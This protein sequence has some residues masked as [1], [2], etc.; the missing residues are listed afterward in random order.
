MSANLPSR[1][2]G[3]AAMSIVLV[4]G[5]IGALFVAPHALAEV[6]L[7]SLSLT[8]EFRTL[9]PVAESGGGRI[10]FAEGGGLA[11]L[12]EFAF[13][14][15]SAGG[16]VGFASEGFNR[17]KGQAMALQARSRLRSG[18]TNSA[19]LF[20]RKPRVPPR[21]DTLELLISHQSL[22]PL[23]ANFTPTPAAEFV[24]Q[25]IADAAAEGQR[26]F[27]IVDVG[28]SGK[29]R[30]IKLLSAEGQVTDTALIEAVRE[31]VKTS[32]QD[33]RRHDHTVYMAYQVQGQTVARVGVPIVTLPEC[34]IV[35]PGCE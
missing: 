33:E 27:A 4:A 13:F 35:P 30:R 15:S 24:P 14:D 11:Y 20:S 26:G 31:G 18:A 3:L 29:I 12:D 8:G 1:R 32:F 25:S 10:G 19:G 17:D 34:I 16:R 6:V 22:H 23:N 7:S 2:R 5:S 28:A 21:T 9:G